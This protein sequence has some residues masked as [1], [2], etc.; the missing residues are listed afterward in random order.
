[1]TEPT[2]DFWGELSVEPTPA[3]ILL[4]QAE[5]LG[6]KT[7]NVLEGLLLPDIDQK[8]QE[9]RVRFAVR[10]PTLEY[11]TTLFELRYSML[12]PYPCSIVETLTEEQVEVEFR[13]DGQTHQIKQKKSRSP[14]NEQD[15]NQAVKEVLQSE[16]V[17]KL[18][19]GLL[20][21]VRVS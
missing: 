20:A 9:V 2:S 11:Q 12:S 17:Q 19:K 5:A 13:F 16:N 3:D 14:A 8:K 18:I 10:A 21:A 4:E 15:L 7:K 1:M 6:L